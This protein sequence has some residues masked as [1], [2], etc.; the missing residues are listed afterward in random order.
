MGHL[1][2]ASSA[3]YGSHRYLLKRGAKEM[4]ANIVLWDGDIDEECVPVFGSECFFLSRI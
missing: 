3:R 2:A 1:T 4:P